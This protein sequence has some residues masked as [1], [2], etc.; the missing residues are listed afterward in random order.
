MSTA[1]EIW[2]ALVNPKTDWDKDEECPT[3]DEIELKLDALE[4]QEKPLETV[5]IQGTTYPV[6]NGK[7]IPPPPKDLGKQIRA[8]KRKRK[9]KK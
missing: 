3:M 2:R 7:P 9:K 4:A 8:R 6:R 1:S 5:V